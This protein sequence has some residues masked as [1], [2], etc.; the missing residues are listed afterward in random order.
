MNQHW[1]RQWLVAW[2]APSHYLNQWWDNVNRTLRNKLQW[3]FKRHWYIFI[4]ENAFE[5]AVWNGRPFS[6]SLNVL[7][8][9]WKQSTTRQYRHIMGCTVACVHSAPSSPLLPCCYGESILWSFCQYCTSVDSH[10]T[11]PHF[12]DSCCLPILL[13]LRMA[14]THW[15]LNKQWS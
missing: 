11:P 1:F 13:V 6:F 8:T 10:H 12:G 7:R 3:N 14:R 4:Q 2:P 15:G 9:T 5:N